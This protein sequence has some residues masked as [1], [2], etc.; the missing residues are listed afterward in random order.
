MGCVNS[1]NPLS[2][3]LVKEYLK[4]TRKEQAGSAITPKQAVPLLFLKFKRLLFHFRGKIAANT[5]L[6]MIN[7]YILVRD[8]TVFVVDFFTGDKASDLG[9][10]SCNQ[11]LRLK[12]Q[13]LWN[14]V[15]WHFQL[16]C[17]IFLAVW[18]SRSFLCCWHSIAIVVGQEQIHSIT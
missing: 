5:S 11:V 6:S 4:F 16:L 7:M 10:L 12:D 2:H 14:I 1:T 13:R 3:S 8:P 18:F 17:G 15:V 9:W